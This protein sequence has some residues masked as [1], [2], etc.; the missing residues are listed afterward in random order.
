MDDAS[1]GRVSHQPHCLPESILGKMTCVACR[2]PPPPPPSF[3]P[4]AASQ[5]HVHVQHSAQLGVQSRL[6]RL[7]QRLILL[8]CA[9]ISKWIC[10]NLS[11]GGILACMMLISSALDKTDQPESASLL[12][13]KGGRS[14][15]ASKAARI[16]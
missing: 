9:S 14:L 7:S 15:A 4:N 5:L 12:R 11:F 1:C 2:K 10:I 6:L 13:R 3:P 8:L 16:E